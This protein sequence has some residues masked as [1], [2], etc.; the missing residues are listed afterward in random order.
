MKIHR[1]EIK[2]IAIAIRAYNHLMRQQILEIISQCPG[3]Y[4]NELVDRFKCEQ[5]VMSQQLAILRRA[6]LVSTKPN[7]KYIQY[8]VKMKS[9]KRL[10]NLAADWSECSVPQP[11]RPIVPVSFC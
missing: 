10:E 5:S 7:G 8:Y 9:L 1:Q 4:V 6:D 3:I 2:E 11:S